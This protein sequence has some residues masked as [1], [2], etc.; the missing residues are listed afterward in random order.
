MGHVL[1]YKEQ[2]KEEKIIL[3]LGHINSIFYNTKSFPKYSN[4]SHNIYTQT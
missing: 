2:E 4:P 1:R 3:N